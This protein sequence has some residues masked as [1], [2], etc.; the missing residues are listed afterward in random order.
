MIENIK[1]DP[2]IKI[3]KDAGKIVREVYD[4]EF[5]VGY[6]EDRS[7]I[8]IADKRSNAFITESLRK[9]YPEIPIIAEESKT[10][11]YEVRKTWEYLWLVDPLD[12]TKEFVSRNGEF[13]VNIA[14]IQHRRPIL[15]VIYVPVKDTVYYAIKGKGAF[16][17]EGENEPIKL[18]V[19]SKNE[20]RVRVIVSRSHYTEETK[21]FVE[22]LRD[23]YGEIEEVHVGSALKL[24]F[25]AEGRADIYPRFAPTMEWDVAAGDIIVSE[26]GGKVL[27]YPSY[28]ELVYNKEKLKNPWFVV[29]KGGI[30]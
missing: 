2:I 27:Q 19:F 11:P 10:V 8:T 24:C 16:K 12:G 28:T 22:R 6:K 7:P 5:S 3:A 23:K 21:E 18:P 17:I 4:T 13:T 14:L 26:S 25:I 30:L 20:E 29:K 9:L 1:I 15:G